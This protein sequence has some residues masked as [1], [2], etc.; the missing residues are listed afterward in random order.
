MIF[1]HFSYELT[2]FTSKCYFIHDFNQLKSRESY[3]CD[4]SISWCTRSSWYPA[5]CRCA[6]APAPPEHPYRASALALCTSAAQGSDLRASHRTS[7][8]H[9]YFSFPKIRREN[10]PVA[11]SSTTASA[12]P[13]CA[14]SRHQ[15]SRHLRHHAY[16][17]FLHA[18]TSLHRG[19]Y[20][21]PMRKRAVLDRLARSASTGDNWTRMSRVC[22]LRLESARISRRWSGALEPD[23]ARLVHSQSRS[24][25]ISR[26]A[27]ICGLWAEERRTAARRQELRSN[28]FPKRQVLFI[29]IPPAPQT[30]L[31]APFT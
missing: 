13:G 6:L 21:L 5:Q 12:R 7:A 4:H 25:M 30:R 31:P 29:A 8:L 24:L 1:T 16:H 28:I 10:A 11:L 26:W 17:R 9:S 20:P 15:G 18:R 23:G 22:T 19:M 3:S 14:V 2:T 27:V